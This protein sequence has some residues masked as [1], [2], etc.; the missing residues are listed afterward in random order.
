MEIRADSVAAR[1]DSLIS[2]DMLFHIA[3]GNLYP[4]DTAKYYRHYYLDT[5]NKCLLKCI[6]DTTFIDY[7][8]R[9]FRQVVIYFNQGYEFRNCWIMNKGINSGICSYFNLYPEANEIMQKPGQLT[10]DWT[11]ESLDK[12]M[13]GHVSREIHWSIFFQRRNHYR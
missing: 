4:A 2:S 8:E 12:D 7:Y 13:K 10:N 9:T 3:F 6:I 5:I 1:T 11:N